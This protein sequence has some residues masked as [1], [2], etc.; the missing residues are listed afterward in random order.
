MTTSKMK[1]I[2]ELAEM[3]AEYNPKDKN[4]YSTVIEAYTNAELPESTIRKVIETIRK[5]IEDSKKIR[6]NI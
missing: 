3:A 4:A 6:A 2:I 1:A 5:L